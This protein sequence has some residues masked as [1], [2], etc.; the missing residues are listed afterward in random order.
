MNTLNVK[1]HT[2]Q[3]NPDLI[4]KSKLNRDFKLRTILID[5]SKPPVYTDGMQMHHTYYIFKYLD[6]NSFFGLYFDG[7]NQV[8]HKLSNEECLEVMRRDM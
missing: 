5:Y 6:D 3:I 2:I 4:Q 1:G 8:K 7:Y